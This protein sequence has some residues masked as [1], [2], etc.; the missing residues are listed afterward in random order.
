[1]PPPVTPL[2]YGSP[3]ST[4]EDPGLVI[5]AYD[6]GYGSPDTLDEAGAI[7]MTETWGDS[8]Y[9][10]PLWI[11]DLAVTPITAADNGGH[12]LT[13]TT[14]EWPYTG[15]HNVT[16]I[17]QQGEEYPCYGL[18]LGEGDSAAV[19]R[20]SGSKLRCATPRL[21]VGIY[22]VRVEWLDDTLSTI[23]MV[24]ALEIVYRQRFPAV[25]ELRS[26][27]QPGAYDVG[28]RALASERVL[29]A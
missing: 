12:I 16:L 24:D 27:F 19:C 23:D 26:R 25:Y 3:S 11:L 9:G 14:I 20:P 6:A 17:D 21:P 10:S 15:D 22:T 4:D 1:M 8:G 18:I 13:I 7:D 29:G 5:T 2:G 28:I